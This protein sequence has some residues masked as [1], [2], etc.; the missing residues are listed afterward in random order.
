M[1]GV[2]HF[3]LPADDLSRAKEFYG[4][5]LWMEVARFPDARW[6][7]VYRCTYDTD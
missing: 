4:S 6:F 7:D 5:I 1:N 2:V 3:E